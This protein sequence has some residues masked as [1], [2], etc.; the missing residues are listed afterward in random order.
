MA[1]ADEV[2][3][4]WINGLVGSFPLLDRVVEWVVSDYLVPASLALTLLGLWFVGVERSVRERN[5]IGVL[6]ALIAMALSSGLVLLINNGALFYHGYFRPRP[7]VD[8]DVSL[9]F[10]E[11]TDSSFP[12]NTAAASFAI[13]AAVWGVNRRVGLALFVAAGLYGFARVYAGVHYPLDILAGAMIGVV[14]AFLV[15]KL[16]DLLE[17]VPTMVIKAARIFCLA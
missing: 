13:A 8:L 12:A 9:L 7:F 11:P 16:K 4:L 2:V 5:Q 6:V 3:F 10:Y 17:P 15:S 14:V 1:H